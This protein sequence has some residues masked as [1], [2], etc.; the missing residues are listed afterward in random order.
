M[1]GATGGRRGGGSVEHRLGR[2]SGVELST[3]PHREGSSQTAERPTR[4]TSQPASGGL[5]AG[6]RWL[7]EHPTILVAAVALAAAIWAVIGSQQV[8]RYLSDDHD[9][10][11]Y[12]L[13][14][15]A[16]AHGHVFPPAP[17]HPDAFVPWLTV[18]AEDK[19]VLKYAPVH[20]SIL[21]VGVRTLGSPRWSLGLIAAGVVVMTYLLAKEVLRDRRLALLASAFLG[22]SPL[23]LVQS[24]TFLP[25]CSSLL[26]LEAFAFTLFRGVRT[27]RGTMLAL[28]G[29]LFGVGLFARPFD[30]L[31]FGAPL[32]VYF[33]VRQ[34]HQRTL[35]VRN[36]AWFGLGIVLPLAAM[37]AYY[38]AATG[39][40]FRPPFNLLEP[41][42]TIGFG[43]RRLLPGH[44][45]IPFTP[46]LGWRGVTRH[47][48]LTS[49]WGFGGL[50]LVGFFVVGLFRRQR[51]GREPWVALV[52]ATFACGYAFFWGTYGTSLKGS[53]TSFLGPFY[54]LPVLACVTLL[55]AKGF[56]EMWRRDSLMT[57]LAVAGMVMVSGYLMAESLKVNLRITEED[58][59]LYRSVEAADLDQALVLLPPMWGPHLLH[60]FNFLQNDADY[61]GE[62][63][64]A[65]DRGEPA[66]LAL[67][68]DHA[69]RAAY[70]LHVHGHY[71]ANPPDPGVRT[72]LERLSVVERPSLET[73][74]TL[75]NPTDDPYVRLSITV[76]GKRDTFLLD[77]SSTAGKSY[78]A[79]FRISPAAVEFQGSS[80]AHVTEP[81]QP[82]GSISIS[83]A[84]GSA[85]G[86]SVRTVY[87]RRWGY[88]ARGPDLKMLF[89][90]TT[91]VN[92]L[93]ADPLEV[94]S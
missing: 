12:L 77:T 45:T 39:S 36:A 18:L 69:G 48:L 16:L 93:G 59:R 51:D 41:Q 15:E 50:L 87:E 4:E 88:M 2:G 80:E 37:L 65:L 70:R 49:F 23:F 6:L 28:S 47:V 1:K 14:A 86:T 72:S 3:H 53:L 63:V 68:E 54:F 34:R 81:V 94:R 11:L 75:T 30:A 29:F 56:G 19:Y 74:V 13:Q 79:A 43:P 57:A 82:D 58:G 27:R 9:E 26:L 21:A 22:L 17:K 67:I 31:L 32:G 60:P 52:A 91:P 24:A 90:G 7:G 38:N 64:Y 71:R 33:L 73:T 83:I 92:E 84:T 55:A 5:A 8:F 89:P 78:E 10:G 85:S 66:N 40:P 46:E 76:N 25:Y 62:T 44:P 42:D 61:D 35:L 20:A